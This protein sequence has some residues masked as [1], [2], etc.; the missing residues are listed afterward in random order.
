MKHKKIWIGAVIAIVVIVAIQLSIYFVQ[1]GIKNPEEPNSTTQTNTVRDTLTTTTM[2]KLKKMGE[3]ERMETYF[4]EYI[5]HVEKKEYEQAYIL[6]NK[7][8]RDKYFPTLEDYTKYMKEKY[9]T[10][11]LVTYNDI[12]RQGNYYI[13]YT[14]ISNPLNGRKDEKA[15]EQR[16]V[17]H[18]RNFNDFELSFNVL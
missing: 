9:P 1:N 2:D 7:D 14:T 18:E 3:R 16:I 10:M 11:I 8:F 15:F 5:S 6:L 13:L 12:E 17:V 4:A